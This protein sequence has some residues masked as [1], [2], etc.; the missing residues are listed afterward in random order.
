[1]QNFQI[2][3]KKVN[4]I[5]EADFSEFVT[6]TYGRPYKFQQQDGCRPRG[7]YWFDVPINQPF[8]YSNTSIPELVNGDEM[9]VSFE[10][11]LNRDP[12]QRLNDGDEWDQEYPEYR[13]ELFWHRNFYPHIEM[14]VA[15]L[16]N[17]DL[18]EDG[19]YVIEI[20]W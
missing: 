15:D 8:N 9:G 18:I 2:P 6:N 3:F 14:I 5:S 4:L 1:M 7:V 11:W 20:D 19:T 17:R 13:I 10:A 16:H 12:Q